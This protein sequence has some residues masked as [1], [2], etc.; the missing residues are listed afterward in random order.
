M[1]WRL[2][3]YLV[4]PVDFPRGR[5]TGVSPVLCSRHLHQSFLKIII[6]LLITNQPITQLNAFKACRAGEDHTR[7]HCCR[8]KAGNWGYSLHDLASTGQQKVGKTRTG[9]NFCCTV[10]MLGSEFGVENMQMQKTR[11]AEARTLLEPW[12][13]SVTCRASR[14]RPGCQWPGLVHTSH[15][16]SESWKELLTT[17]RPKDNIPYFLKTL[18]SFMA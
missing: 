13:R 8:L 11:P 7:C 17:I 4:Y 6:W 14:H 12:T 16:F 5:H 2:N 1:R 9:L 15:L 3:D 18:L 10:Q